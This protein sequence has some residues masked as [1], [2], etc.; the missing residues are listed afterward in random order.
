MTYIEENGKKLYRIN[1]ASFERQGT[2]I[3][4]NRADYDKLDNVVYCYENVVV[5][6][7]SGTR[8]PETI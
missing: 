7:A 6:E 2:N 5:T 1:Q 3:T 8:V 4:C